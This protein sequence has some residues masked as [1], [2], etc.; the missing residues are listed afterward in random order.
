MMGPAAVMAMG[1]V[2]LTMLTEL[3]TYPLSILW[4]L[5]EA[6]KA[7]AVQGEIPPVHSRKSLVIHV[8]GAEIAFECKI[9]TN[10]RFYDIFTIQ[11]KEQ[12]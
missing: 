9:T 2:K 12:N 3:A 10:D 8:V 6:S 7:A 4:G 5:Q 1:K 11:S